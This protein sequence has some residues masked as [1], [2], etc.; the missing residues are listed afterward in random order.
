MSPP[1]ATHHAKAVRAVAGWAVLL[2]LTLGANTLKAANTHLG[3]VNEYL[4]TYP[5]FPGV[6]EAP[7]LVQLDDASPVFGKAPSHEVFHWPAT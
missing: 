1:H 4:S 7:I 6:Y 2:T 5:E 3:S